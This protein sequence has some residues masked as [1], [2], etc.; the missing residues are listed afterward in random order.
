MKAL[1]VG[2]YVC[3]DRFDSYWRCLCGLNVTMSSTRRRR[4]SDLSTPGGLRAARSLESLLDSCFQRDQPIPQNFE[5]IGLLRYPPK[6]RRLDENRD[7]VS[8]HGRAV[9]DRPR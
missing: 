2:S 5:H 8:R 9:A 3:N 7:P 6:T 1:C 4:E